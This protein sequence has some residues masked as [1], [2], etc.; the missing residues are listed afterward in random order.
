M[1]GRWSL[2]DKRLRRAICSSR[3]IPKIPATGEASLA[4]KGRDQTP[5]ARNTG[6]RIAGYK[7]PRSFDLRDEPLPLSAAGKILKT[8][9]RALN[10]PNA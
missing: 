3:L 6:E 7:C 9:L 8:E 1:I 10:L 4:I 5:N 2:A